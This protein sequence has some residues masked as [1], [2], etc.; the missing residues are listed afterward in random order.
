MSPPT[1]TSFA[2]LGL[3]GMQSWTAYELVAQS[4][5]S[6]HWFWPRSEAHLYAELKRIVAR[7]HAEA[8]VVEGRKGHKQRTRYTITE[9]GREAL[10][11]WL[12]T[13]PAPVTLEVEGMLRL[14]LGDQGNSDDLRTALQAVARQ[15]HEVRAAGVPLV[16]D[17]LATGG[18]FPERL[19][20]IAPLITFYDEFNQLIIRWCNDTLA[21]IDSWPDV[22]DVGLT[23]QGRRRLQQIIG[24]DKPGV[25]MRGQVTPPRSHERGRAEKNVEM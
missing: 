24:N 17:L 20:L 10:Q 8:E 1:P 23:P 9:Q 12:G 3:L 7:G 22:R 14:L 4:R 6:L 18:P 5:R 21:E 13:E 19:H 2:I 25:S 11:E 16:A 15:A